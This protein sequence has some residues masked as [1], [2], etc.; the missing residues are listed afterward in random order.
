MVAIEMI[1][2][3]MFILLYNLQCIGQFILADRNNLAI[4]WL[5]VATKASSVARSLQLSNVDLC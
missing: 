4:F 3:T 1:N 2:V 5:V